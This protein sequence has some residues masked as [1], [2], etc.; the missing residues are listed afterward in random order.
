MECLRLPTHHEALRHVGN[1]ADLILEMDGDLPEHV[2]IVHLRV[3]RQREHRHVVNGV[4]LD[5]Q[6][7]RTRRRLITRTG[8]LCLHAR[9]ASLLI[10]A[11]LESHRHDRISVAGHRVHVIHAG[12][13]EHPLLD[14]PRE[15]I[16][17]LPG[18]GARERGDDVDHRHGDL[19]LLLSRRRQNREEPD[20]QR[21]EGDERS[22]LRAQKRLRDLAGEPH[23]QSLSATDGSPGGGTTI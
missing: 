17:G 14:R 5:E 3:E 11:H 18:S 15:E 16:L 19:R 23:R 13:L 2:R 1:R 7:Q 9:H 22:E 12:E 21:C 4:R 8:E 10:F 20:R 6:R